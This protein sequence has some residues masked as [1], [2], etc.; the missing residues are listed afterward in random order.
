M[1]FVNILQMELLFKYQKYVNEIHFINMTIFKINEFRYATRIFMILNLTQKYIF[2]N[3]ISNNN[4]KKNN[5][6]SACYLFI[7]KFLFVFYSSSFFS[8]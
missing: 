6:N 2:K 1:K 3:N 8:K 5:K 7:S 4:N